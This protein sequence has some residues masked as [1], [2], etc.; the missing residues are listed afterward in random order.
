MWQKRSGRWRW[1]FIPFL[2]LPLCCTAVCGLS[3]L[4][5][6]LN[7]NSPGALAVVGGLT[8]IVGLWSL[9]SFATWGVNLITTVAAATVIARERETLNWPLLRVTTLAPQEILG[10]KIAALLAWLRWPIA[11]LLIARVAAVLATAV[12]AAVLVLFAPRLDPEVT[13]SMQVALWMFTALGA[14]FMTAFLIV[15]LA[16]SLLYNCAIGLL[17]SAVSRSSATAVA[18]TFVLNLV[19]VLFV[20]APAQQAATIGLAALSNAP[21]PLSGF[22]FPISAGLA[23]FFLPLFLE[24]ALAAVALMIVVDQTKRLVE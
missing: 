8:L 21:L 3:L 15:E 1:L 4:P 2:F 20:F 14:A 19:L 5:A 11:A 18:V 17:S 7:D 13:A 9:H 22:V 6:A 24:S 16:A 10:A 23:G 12:G